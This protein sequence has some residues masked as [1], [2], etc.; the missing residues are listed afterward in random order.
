MMGEGASSQRLGD[1]GPSWALSTLLS[2]N[3][4]ESMVMVFHITDNPIWSY[5]LAC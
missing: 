1:Y 4:P 3:S 2:S 5:M